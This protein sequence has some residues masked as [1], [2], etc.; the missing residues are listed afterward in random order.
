MIIDEQLISYEKF[1]IA[2]LI[3]LNEGGE[4]DF[5]EYESLVLPLLEKY[6]GKPEFRIRPAAENFIYPVEG[7]LPF[8]LHIVSFETK[9]DFLMFKDDPVRT[10]HLELFRRAVKRVV[11]LES[12]TNYN[13]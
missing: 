3:Y 7:E 8:E 9:A 2:Q 10:K 1:T 11:V 4:K 12:D 13:M 5:L 6:N